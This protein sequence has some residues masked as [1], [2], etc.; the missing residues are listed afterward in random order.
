MKYKASLNEI[1]PCKCD[2]GEGL[3]VNDSFAIWVDITNN[4]IFFYDKKRLRKYL[5]KSKPSVV[6]FANK[7]YVLLGSDKGLVRF[8]FE[9]KREIVVSQKG[10]EHDK[11]TY[12]SNDGGVFN[13]FIYLSFMHRDQPE[14]YPGL[15]Y[16]LED[17]T[18]FLQEKS[19]FIP[20]TFIDLKDF[21]LISDSFKNTIWSFEHNDVS[22]LV[23]KRLWA[24]FDNKISPDGGCKIEE[25]IFVSLWDDASIAVLDRNG[26]IT[27][28]ISLPV[29]RPT[30]CKFNK[31]HSQ[32]WITSAK[33]GLDKNQIDL[34][35]NSGDTFIYD[36]ELC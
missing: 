14:S 31:E 7:D 27:S 1:I 18:F 9:D 12:R 25:S 26:K 33:E 15:I 24:K 17:D 22:N 3:Y 13:N 10:L 8:Y 11:K 4:H 5:L 16:K 28:K 6:Y 20:N 35:P 21:F 34:Y 32:L 2:L 29:L 19:V 30:N 23:N 36:L